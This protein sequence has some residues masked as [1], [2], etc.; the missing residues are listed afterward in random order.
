V[1]LDSRYFTVG[2]IPGDADNYYGPAPGA[3]SGV[4]S[5]FSYTAERDLH[6]WTAVTVD[7]NIYP[8]ESGGQLPFPPLAPWPD[9]ADVQDFIDRFRDVGAARHRYLH[10]RTDSPYDPDIGAAGLIRLVFRED[11]YS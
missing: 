11:A 4:R 8:D 10:T 9:E 7:I 6:E 3:S 5:G 2:N 1:P